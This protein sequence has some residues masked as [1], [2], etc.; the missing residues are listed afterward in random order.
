MDII[1]KYMG[2][3]NDNYTNIR[4]MC[5][6]VTCSV[7][8]TTDINNCRVLLMITKVIRIP[9]HFTKNLLYW[10]YFPIKI[11]DS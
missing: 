11:I 4:L 9:D 6:T 2:L 8:V 1:H 5:S 10:S 3:R 7:K